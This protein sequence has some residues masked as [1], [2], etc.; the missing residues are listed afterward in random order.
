M[1]I[2]VA[3]AVLVMPLLALTTAVCLAEAPVVVPDDL[4]VRARVTRLTPPEPTDIAW[5][6]G[7]EGLGGEVRRGTHGTRSF[8][9]SVRT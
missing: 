9:P 5:R 2:P 3:R 1:R 8:T 4:T 7:G 6:W